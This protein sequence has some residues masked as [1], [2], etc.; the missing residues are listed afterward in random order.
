[1]SSTASNGCDR[2]NERLAR[3]VDP[4]V[5]RIHRDEPRARALVAYLALD[6][7]LDV[8][9]EEDVGVAGRGRQLR[10]EVREDIQLGRLCVRAVEVEVVVAAPVERAPAGDL[11]DIGGIDAPLVQRRV[12]PLAEVVAHRPD[13]AHVAEERRR[14]REVHGRAAQH[15]LALAERRADGIK[16]DRTYDGEGH[17]GA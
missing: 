12:L 11:L 9:E 8:G 3:R 10:L 5:H 7:G 13:D 17:E 2:V 6:A 16:G 15:P 4:V 14:Q 1:M